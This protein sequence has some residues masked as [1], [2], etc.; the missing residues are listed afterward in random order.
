M[1]FQQVSNS[2]LAVL[3]CPFNHYIEVTEIPHW[4]TSLYILLFY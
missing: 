1:Y 3:E 4:L 2:W